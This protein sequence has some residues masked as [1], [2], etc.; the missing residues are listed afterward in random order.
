M[1]GQLEHDLRSL[2]IADAERGPAPN[3]L[4]MAARRRARRLATIRV[5]RVVIPSVAAASLVAAIA[6]GAFPFGERAAKN[7][8]AISTSDIDKS[9]ATNRPD[10]NGGPLPDL[11]DSV[12]LCLTYGPDTLADA[13]YAFDGT[14]EKIESSQPYVLSPGVEL[15]QVTV[16]FEVHEWYRGGQSARVP[17]KMNP[18]D[19]I[20]MEEIATPAYQVGTRLLVSGSVRPGGEFWDDAFAAGCGFTR[21]YDDATADNW[22]EV[23]TE[24]P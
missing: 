22:R 9:G 23:F 17:V 5:A 10:G 1:N 16:T 6:A 21:Y 8:V 4:A 12:T 18:P 2:F 14:V 11:Q 20:T 15:P 7:P 13:R 3:G 19:D 24:L